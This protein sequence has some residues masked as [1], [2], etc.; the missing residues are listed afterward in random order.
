MHA[1]TSKRI[2]ACA[3]GKNLTIR[4][5][6]TSSPEIA[7]R[8]PVRRA[9]HAHARSVKV[10]GRATVTR[11]LRFAPN[12]RDWVASQ[13]LLT[14]WRVPFVALH[15][16][17]PAIFLVAEEFHA[18]GG[19]LNWRAIVVRD[20]YRHGRRDNPVKTGITTRYRYGAT[21]AMR[22]FN[23]RIVYRRDGSRLLYV[24]IGGRKR[25]SGGRRAA[26]LRVARD[27]DR[28]WTCRQAR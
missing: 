6:R 8:A 18:V 11:R 1:G 7:N 12:P 26:Q 5:T 28:D 16:A 20:V 27:R 4:S 9:R 23:S 21:A 24:P 19:S 2:H 22:P 17:A 3:Q 14:G 25:K 15:A 13:Q 10:P